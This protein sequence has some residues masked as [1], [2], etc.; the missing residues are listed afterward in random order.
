MLKKVKINIFSSKEC[1]ELTI[2]SCDG[3]VIKNVVINSKAS[4][5]CFCTRNDCVKLFAKH[6]NQIVCKKIC[7]CNLRCQ[8]IFV[9]FVFN[10]IFS[11]MVFKTICL[12]DLNYG[13]PVHN[14]TLCFKQIKTYFN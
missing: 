3:R 1:F 13:L 6:K 14:A 8:N 11:K 4:K 9:N 10:K 12:T 2:M 5:I 7:L